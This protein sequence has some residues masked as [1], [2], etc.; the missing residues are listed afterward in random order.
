[1]MMPSR[2]E[3]SQ[4]APDAPQVEFGWF[5]PLRHPKAAV[6]VVAVGKYLH[7]GDAPLYA[8]V[9]TQKVLNILPIPKGNGFT[10]TLAQMPHEGDRLYFK[11][12]GRLETRTE[13][14]YHSGGEPANVA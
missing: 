13:V 14:V 11:Y 1:M 6:A 4:P 8:R 2:P 7:I 3:S 12:L 10:G 5:Q 9:G